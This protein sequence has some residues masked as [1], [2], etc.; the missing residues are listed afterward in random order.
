[1]THKAHKALKAEGMSTE[2]ATLEALAREIQALKAVV[3]ARNG[4]PGDQLLTA[5][6]VAKRLHVRPRWVYEQS[7]DLPFTVRLGPKLLRFSE[8]GLAR[9]LQSR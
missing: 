7:G 4:Q 1:M 9:W 3:T 8:R 5:T 6:E 2:T